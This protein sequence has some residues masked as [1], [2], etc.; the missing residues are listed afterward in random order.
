MISLNQRREE[1][2]YK[3][4][5][6]L[7]IIRNYTNLI[8]KQMQF[9]NP[10]TF[11]YALENLAKTHLFSREKTIP[12]AL[13]YMAQEMDS[14][15]GR[16]L[17]GGDV[18]G[19]T[20]FITECRTRISQSIKSFAEIYYKAGKEGNLIR[21][22][23]EDEESP[24]YQQLEKSSRVINDVVKSITVYKVIDS[25]AVNVARTLTKVRSSHAISISNTITDIKYVDN[26][27]IILELFIKE[28][29]KVGHLCG[30]EFYKNVRTLMAIKRTKSMIYFKQQINVLLQL[31]LK[32]MNFEKEFNQLTSQTQSLISLY[33]AYYL[34]L[35]LKN[36]IC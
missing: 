29:S 11:K 2:S 16:N 22:P 34:T 25:K 23:T 33:L 36:S 20:K 8:H 27:R 14:R 24:Q 13:F 18:E 7:F 26:I 35:T 28:L 19:V 31:V 12:G 9:C 4:A 30:D 32:D 21:N 1:S 17:K 15:Y 3:S 6:I 5:L 10:D